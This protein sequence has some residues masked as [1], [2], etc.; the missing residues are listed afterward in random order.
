MR[1]GFLHNRIPGPKGY[2]QAS[3]PHA[4]GPAELHYYPPRN[5]KLPKDVIVF[6][7]GQSAIKPYTNEIDGFTYRL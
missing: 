2:V 7:P 1:C 5:G 4:R 6:I 3:F